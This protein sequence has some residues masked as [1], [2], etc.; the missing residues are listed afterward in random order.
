MASEVSAIAP[1]LPTSSD[2]LLHRMALAS[3]DANLVK[4]YLG[5]VFSAFLLGHLHTFWPR[6]FRAGPVGRGIRRQLAQ[7]PGTHLRSWLTR[8]VQ[9]LWVRSRHFAVPMSALGQ[10]QTFAL[11]RIMSA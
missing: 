10:K 4:I 7:C 9:A 11:H 8:R 6:L 5:A 3:W 2:A 1:Q